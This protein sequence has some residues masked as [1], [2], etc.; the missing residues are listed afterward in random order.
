[1]AYGRFFCPLAGRFSCPLPFLSFRARI[2]D[3]PS[4]LCA[5][6]SGPIMSSPPSSSVYIKTGAGLSAA[7]SSTLGAAD[8]RVLSLI[9]GRRSSLDISI[10]AGISSGKTEQILAAL[11]KSGYIRLSD[12]PSGDSSGSGSSLTLGSSSENSDPI[13]ISDLVSLGEA[14]SSSSKGAPRALPK[15]DD[16]DSVDI[17]SIISSARARSAADASSRKGE[18]VLR[19]ADRDAELRAIEDI[20]GGALDRA[21]E[22]KLEREKAERLALELR[23]AEESRKAAKAEQARLRAALEAREREEAERRAREEAERKAREEAER[24]IREE[25]ERKAREEREAIERKAREERERLAAIEQARL[26]RIGVIRRRAQISLGI[27]AAALFSLGGVLSYRVSLINPAECSSIAKGWLG[28]PV[29]VSSCSISLFPTPVLSMG[30]FVS[31][32]AFAFRS[33]KA[34]IALI[35][36]ISGEKRLESVSLSNGTS[37]ADGILTLF[38]GAGASHDLR[39]LRNLDIDNLSLQFGP[40]IIG[41]FSA[42]AVLSAKGAL[43]QATFEAPRIGLDGKALF[44]GPVAMLS[45]SVPTLPKGIA[46]SSWGD[47]SDISAQGYLEPSSFRFDALTARNSSGYYLAKGFVSWT[48]TQWVSDATWDSHGVDLKEMAPWLFSFG[49]A[50]LSGDFRSTSESFA[51]LLPLGVYKGSGEAREFSVNVDL[52]AASGVGSGGGRTAFSPATR[53]VVRSDDTGFSV[54]LPSL[55]SG[56]L[57]ANLS[58]LRTDDGIVSGSANISSASGNFSM[59]LAGDDKLLNLSR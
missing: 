35:P 10:V 24:K 33:V 15:D 36:L 47:V 59:T 27:L 12:L 52:A 48:P 37:T 32:G 38:R 22:A 6:N 29:S 30:N 14:L 34:S 49:R 18:K 44:S 41:G 19:S 11:E 57:S 1:M 9:D 45:I 4:T 50:S 39:Y 2:P 13:D 28:R 58:A 25:A 43:D 53:L 42:K 17:S 40:E 55:S 7:R 20:Y 5:S 21:L 51:K 3:D 31:D 23:A 46:P 26:R 16:D 54:G 56:I 8:K